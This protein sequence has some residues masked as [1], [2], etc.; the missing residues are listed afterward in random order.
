M[1]LVIDWQF[2]L[3]W[4]CLNLSCAL[5]PLFPCH[6]LTVSIRFKQHIF[7]LT[8]QSQTSRAIHQ[9]HIGTQTQPFS[10]IRDVSAGG[11][12]AEF[13]VVGYPEE[14]THYCPHCS[15]IALAIPSNVRLRFLHLSGPGGI[16][17]ILCSSSSGAA[18]VNKSPPST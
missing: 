15:A 2:S 16:V 14:V 9:P 7:S 18:G 11:G 3:I 8:C 10:F 17:C 6:H 1:P 12:V 5:G 13:A 4:K